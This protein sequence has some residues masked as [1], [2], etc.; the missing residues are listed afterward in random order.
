MR[1]NF[2]IAIC[3]DFNVDRTIFRVKLQ[4]YLNEH[5]YQI[6]IDEFS[7]GDDLLAADSSAYGLVIM[8]IYMLGMNG[9]E[10]A[11]RLI[12]KNPEIKI[13]LCSSSNEYAAESY[14]IDAIRYLL[15][16]ISEEKFYQSLD[17]YFEKYTEIEQI[18]FRSMR[19]E[20]MIS[21]ENVLWI[22][23]HGKKSIIHTI[24]ETIETTNA[25]A[26][27]MDLLKT[28][29]FVRP[30]RYAMV[31]KSAIKKHQ[32]NV[33]ILTDGTEIPVSRTYRDEIEKVLSRE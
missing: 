19:S 13:I 31:R 4:Q 25:F 18:M 22:E 3:D 16:P 9:I 12:E 27:Y 2:K 29:E 30:I 20:H 21:K 1:Y 7:S 5:N 8:D 11:K 26:E 15:K 17:I 10:T 23:A 14:D 33:L 24:E 28:G 32:G 6:E